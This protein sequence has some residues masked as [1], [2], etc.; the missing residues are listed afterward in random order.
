[1]KH[2]EVVLEEYIKNLAQSRGIYS[3]LRETWTSVRE[4]RIKLIDPDPPVTFAAYSFRLC[5]SLW[6]WASL[7]F[8]LLTCV[9]VYTTDFV[10]LLLPARYVFA[11]LYVLFLPGYSLVEALYPGEGD[12][13][14]LERVALSIG[15]SLAV[16]PLIGLVLN[17]TQWG[18]R[19]TP[20]VAS[21][22]IFTTTMLIIALYRKYSIYKLSITPTRRKSWSSGRGKVSG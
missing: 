19:L 12:L 10:P 17:Y 13:S 21:T 22:A 18:I 2:G 8:I 16:V 14:P 11:T 5:Y 9:L 3:V 7:A 15:L 20:V 1:M 4:G 6:F